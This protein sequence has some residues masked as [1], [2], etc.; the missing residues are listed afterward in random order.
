M[1][2]QP[3]GRVVGAPA[4]LNAPLNTLAARDTR[5]D[6]ER[7]R[8]ALHEAGHAVADVL[9]GLPIEYASIRAGRTF[10]GIE[11]P[12]PRPV[13]DIDRLTIYPTLLQP[14]ALRNNIERRVIA[15]LAGQ[16]AELYLD[17]PSSGYM[18]DE[19]DTIARQALAGLGA[20]LVELVVEHEER[21]E[22]PG[23]DESRAFDL[24]GA[25][26]GP[27]S[28]GL[29]L[30]LLRH[31]ARALVIRYHLAILRVADALERQAILSGDQVAALIYPRGRLSGG[32]FPAS[33]VPHAARTATEA[34]ESADNAH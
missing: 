2:P 11:V 22:S 20:R 26:V 8:I 13:P 31:E 15:T 7:R 33:E 10:A 19:A 14:T 34:D 12:V 29:Y 6:L 28:A 24:A 1:S 5:D 9:L 18:S 25:M 4:L 17:E 27:D 32:A 30:E 16:L 21:E 23:R 3:R